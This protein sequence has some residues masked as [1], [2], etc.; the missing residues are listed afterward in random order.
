MPQ[1]DSLHEM[2][3]EP[4]SRRMWLISVVASVASTALG[5][6]LL[7]GGKWITGGILVAVVVVSWASLIPALWRLYRERP[8]GRPRQLD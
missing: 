1:N 5:I 3:T 4:V 2:L 7:A 6:V 8:G